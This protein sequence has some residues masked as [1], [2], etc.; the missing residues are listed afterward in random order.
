MRQSLTLS[1]AFSSTLDPLAGD[2]I[3]LVAG[4][5]PNPMTIG[6]ATFGHIWNRPVLTV[7]VRPV[8]YT[9]EKM[10]AVTDFSVCVLPE[11]LKTALDLCGT[12]SGRDIDKLAAAGLHA[13][14]CKS[15]NAFFL[16]E[17]ILHFEC[18]IIHKHLLDPSALNPAILK[19]YYPKNDFHMVYYGEIL[20]IY[21]VTG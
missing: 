16:A 14:K 13:E 11:H 3:L 19:R 4:D 15:A 21:G 17:S 1:E 20:G 6:W 10:E 7:M 5:L 9:Y 12:R 8:R 18:R 2:G